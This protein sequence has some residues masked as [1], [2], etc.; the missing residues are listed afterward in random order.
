MPIHT[1]ESAYHPKNK[2]SFLI[3]WL[4]TL[5]CNY[6]CVYCPIGP[7]GHD[8]SKPHPSVDRSIIMIDQMYQYTDVV[9][10]HKGARFKDVIMNIYGGESIYHPDIV[11][12]IQKTSEMYESYKDRWR[13]RRRITTNG[14]AAE[15]IW[16]PIC[17]HIEGFTMSY[18]STGPDKLK[19][20]FKKNLQYLTEIKKEHDL[21]VC[22]YP[23]KDH[24]HDCI[25]FLRWAQDSGIHARP[26]MLDGNCGVYN[27]EH[28][29][30]L[31]EFID[32]NELKEWDTDQKADTQSRG[33]CGGRKMCVN[34]NIREYQFLVPRESKGFKGWHCSAN[35]FF[36]HGNNSSGE[37]YTN[38]DCR[39]KLDGKT[40]AIANINTMPQY[41]ENMKQQKKLPTLVCA[42]NTC[43]CGTCA[44][45]SI[46]KEK[47]TEILNIYNKPMPVDGATVR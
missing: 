41:I 6:D 45:K 16:K 29:K 35:Q 37:Y 33:C 44:P 28:L 3:D 13:L 15:K 25:D 38:K 10:S 9:L 42:Q 4:V 23:E 24:W 20:L 5:K 17:E 18:H 8:N 21:I 7:S 31:E 34:R 12:L 30:D 43:R 1:L 22:M 47:L 36:L 2:M 26:K 14:T 32:E 40:G 19:K 11:P 39:V 27:K 46:Y